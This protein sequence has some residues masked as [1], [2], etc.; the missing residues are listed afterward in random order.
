MFCRKIKT[1]WY[2][3]K[4]DRPFSL[5]RL[6][7]FL[8]FWLRTLKIAAIFRILQC[9]ACVKKNL[10]FSKHTKLKEIKPKRLIQ[11]KDNFQPNLSIP[12]DARSRLLA[13]IGDPKYNDKN[14]SST[15][16]ST[17]SALKLS[18]WSPNNLR[19]NVLSTFYS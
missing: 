14:Y 5:K 19:E 3:V 18:R 9:L 15:C 10:L 12:A 17:K 11:A 8:L 2:N 6:T 1:N 16:E 4:I 13:T 7:F